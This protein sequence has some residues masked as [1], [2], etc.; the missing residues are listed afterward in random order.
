MMRRKFRGPDIETEKKIWISF[1]GK[2]YYVDVF[3][4]IEEDYR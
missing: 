1:P 4:S 3:A 2:L